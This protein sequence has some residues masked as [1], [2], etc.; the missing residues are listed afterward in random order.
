MKNVKV[1]GG[2]I[3]VLFSLFLPSKTL[4][5]TSESDLALDY[6]KQNLNQNGSINCEFDVLGC[7]TW[8]IISISSQKIDPQEFK[9][10]GG[11]SPIDYV[12]EN[13]LSLS[14]ATDYARTIMA[15]ESANLDSSNFAEQNLVNALK[16]KINLEAGNAEGDENGSVI[17]TSFAVLALAWVGEEIPENTI[18]YIKD[19]Q[20]EDGGFSSGWGEEA[21]VTSQAVMALIAA[22]VLANDQVIQNALVF[23]GGLQ[24]ETGGFKYDNS[25]WTAVAD[26]NTTAI[27][28][29]ALLSAGEDPLSDEWQTNGKNVYNGLLSFQKED[30]SFRYSDDDWG[31]GNP[32]F[33]LTYGAGIIPALNNL[34][35]PFNVEFEDQEDQE[36]QN[37]EDVNDIAPTPNP[38]P[39]PTPIIQPQQ[40]IVNL[41]SQDN[42]TFNLSTEND[43][44]QTEDKAKVLETSFSKEPV[45]N[46]E[47]PGVLG[48]KTSNT[49]P[50]YLLGLLIMVFGFMVGNFIFKRIKND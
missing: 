14:S 5:S 8:G 22:G 39:T 30:G 33:T 32:V 48:A 6:I 23:L 31:D 42:K 19:N 38:T 18:Q 17:N 13:I 41:A 29:Q 10:E 50:N 43:Q 4:A 16:E 9:L 47:E 35:L 2:V 20:F 44:P 25:P 21:Q 49:T 12:E 3:L 40:A 45:K 7:T 34:T 1:F 24:T 27:V 28:S 11:E 36:D 37:E 26:S 15:L 46:N